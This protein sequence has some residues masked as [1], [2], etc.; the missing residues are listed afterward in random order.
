MILL[1]VFY[2]WRPI[3]GAFI[4]HLL[5][6]FF[7]PL[8]LVSVYLNPHANRLPHYH[9]RAVTLFNTQRRARRAFLKA[10][11]LFVWVKENRS[12]IVLFKRFISTAGRSKRMT[13]HFRAFALSHYR[14]AAT[15]RDQL[16]RLPSKIQE[17]FTR[18]MSGLLPGEQLS[19]VCRACL[20]PLQTHAQEITMATIASCSEKLQLREESKSKLRPFAPTQ[21]PPSAH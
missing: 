9:V 15:S 6:L 13:V 18:V 14:I 20:G 12:K 17:T 8:Y 16:C 7:S 4:L 19:S 3:K 5:S 10:W 21:N 2:V 11:R 1:K